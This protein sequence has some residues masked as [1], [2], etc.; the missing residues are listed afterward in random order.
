MVADKKFSHFV[1]ID[2]SG[3][4]GGRHAGIALALC[5][6][7]VTAP[8]LILP[9]SGRT[10]WSR[11]EVCDWIKNGCGQGV[12]AQVLV[13]I[14][15][16]FSMPFTDKNAYLDD[17]VPVSHAVALWDSV[18]TSCSQGFD[19]YGGDFVLSHQQHY[20]RTGARGALFSRRM[21][22]T[23]TRAIESGAGPCESVFHLI[24]PSQVG[25]SAL[26]TMRMLTR[27]SGQKGL[28]IWPFE[29]PVS[30][31]ITLTEIYAAA[32]A[33][34]GGHQ[35]KIRD[36]KLL[37]QVLSTLGSRPFRSGNILVSDH[38]ADAIITSAALRTIAPERKY[39]H[40]ALLSSKVRETEGWVFGIL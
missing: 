25:L 4:K 32:F 37:N 30:A 21:R 17:T 19:L 8:K 24:G 3:A 40:P 20:H 36:I 33:K 14:D 10:N 27:L 11:Q 38:A 5:E 15:S 23:E 26:S 35:G 6:T 1:G 2:W 39:W 22:R 31:Q 13:G 16:A 28:A 12:G 29:D 18:E 9:P 34:M 7:G